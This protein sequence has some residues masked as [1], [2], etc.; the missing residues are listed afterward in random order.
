[1]V[2]L[3]YWEVFNEIVEN[4]KELLSLADEMKLIT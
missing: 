1:M 2:K 3:L 4:L